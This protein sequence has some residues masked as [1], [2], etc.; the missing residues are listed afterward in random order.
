MDDIRSLRAG[1]VLSSGGAIVLLGLLCAVSLGE[2]RHSDAEEAKYTSR[3]NAKIK[4][5]G[6]RSGF[7]F[8]R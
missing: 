7:L 3:Y 8:H 6:L 5:G 1:S 2:H 4:K